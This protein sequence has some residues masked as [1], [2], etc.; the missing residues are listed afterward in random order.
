MSVKS[1]FNYSSRSYQSTNLAKLSRI[2]YWSRGQR[3]EYID[4]R[5]YYALRVECTYGVSP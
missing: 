3:E 2:V 5:A 1:K 4:L